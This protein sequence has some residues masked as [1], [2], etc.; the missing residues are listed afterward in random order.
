MNRLRRFFPF[1]AWW[2]DLRDPKVVR[3]DLVAGITVA[4]VL[5]PQSMAYA[6]LAGLPAYYGLYAAFLP[7]AIAALW[8]S[9]RQLA[10]G[11]VAMVSLMTGAALVPFAAAG[12]DV[13]PIAIALALLA[14]II[15]LAMGLLRLGLLVDFLSHPVLVG[16]TNAA[17]VVIATSQLDKLLGVRAA[18]ASHHL[19]TVWNVCVAAA[20]GVHAPAIGMGLLAFF[21]MIASRKIDKR[22]PGVLLAVLVT[23]TLAWKFDYHQEERP[24]TACLAGTA[25]ALVVQW[26]QER[27]QEAALD[28]RIR[29]AEAELERLRERYGAK[30]AQVAQARLGLDELRLS[31][32][33]RRREERARWEALR[34]LRYRRVDSAGGPTWHAVGELPPGSR[35]DGREWRLRS[36][37]D[38]GKVL[39]VAGGNVV[40]AVPKGLPSIGVPKLGLADLLALLPSALM[41][42]LIGFVEAISIAKSMALQT[43]QRVD[44]NQELI[45]QGLANLTGAVTQAY[46]VSGSFSRS[47]VNLSAGA[48]TGFAAVVTSLA[49]IAVLLWLT[50]L[51]WHLPE[52]TLAAVI[53]MAV[54]NLVKVK[55]ILHAWKV[56]PRDA[57]VSLATFAITLLAAPHL[58][59]GILAGI[60]LSLVVYLAATMRPEVAVLSRHGDGSL[61]DAAQHDLAQ[62]DRI[63]ILRFDGRLYFAN[64]SHFEDRLIAELAARADVRVVV[65]AGAGLNSIDSTGEEVLHRLVDR[66]EAQGLRVIFWGLRHRV[67]EILARTGLVARLGG[68]RFIPLPDAALEEARRLAG[69]AD[70]CKKDC[71]LF[72]S[73][74]A[75]TADAGA[76]GAARLSPR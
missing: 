62:C 3:A 27:V 39:L 6:Q 75:A 15:Q 63:L 66:L 30:H 11:P 4:L 21:L 49:V 25:A 74:P 7:P 45:G 36:M 12:Q 23:T 13:V 54:A 58:D 17:A 28:P 37:G 18:K 69:C 68:D 59:V 41:L 73:K 35:D 19:E 24:P 20:Q 60:G 47:A 64:T 55:P 43:R 9:S 72:V 42:S 38:D 61:R 50:P 5:I 52:A 44:A 70:D 22:I 2:K 8:G 33:D 46:P 14:G 29:E 65:F 56:A 48:V 76:R 16:V 34:G 10:T 57:L 32:D 1:L 67:Q 31:L 40:G 26:E 53:M 51:L 71:P